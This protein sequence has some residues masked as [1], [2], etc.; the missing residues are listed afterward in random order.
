[1]AFQFAFNTKYVTESN[2]VLRSPGKY[3]DGSLRL[4]VLSDIGEPL[5]TVTVCMS[6]YG[7][8]P[9]QGY[10]FVKDYSENEGTVEAL[11]DAGII[12]VPERWLSPGHTAMGV[13]ECKLLV[14]V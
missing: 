7:E 4:D 13:A 1:M 5:S 2:A 10:V 12:S 9:K 14:E 8:T 11:M 6:Q 3:Q